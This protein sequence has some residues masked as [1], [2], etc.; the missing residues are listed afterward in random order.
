MKIG[1][2]VQYL[3]YILRVHKNWQMGH[4]G[5]NASQNA[6][7]VYSVECLITSKKHYTLN[8]F[9]WSNWTSSPRWSDLDNGLS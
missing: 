1:D 4:S 6:S 9:T 8:L 3:Q 5:T 7:H 2:S